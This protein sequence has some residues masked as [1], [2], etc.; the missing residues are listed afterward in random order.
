MPNTHFRELSLKWI[1]VSL[2]SNEEILSIIGDV[3]EK[4][5]LRMKRFFRMAT[6]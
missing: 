4:T 5:Y 3:A 1:P 6:G 2:S